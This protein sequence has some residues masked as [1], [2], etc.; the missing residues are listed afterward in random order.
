[1]RLSFLTS[2]SRCKLP[3]TLNVPYITGESNFIGP[4]G[5]IDLEFTRGILRSAY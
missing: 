1:M 2:K 5:S 4:D 3:G